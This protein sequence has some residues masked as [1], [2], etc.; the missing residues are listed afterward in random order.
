[1]RDKYFH[2]NIWEV[3]KQHIDYQLQY[4]AYLLGMH[5][6]WSQ[7]NKQNYQDMSHIVGLSHCKL[8]LL[9]SKSRIRCIGLAY[10]LDNIR[11]FY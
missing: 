5:S 4:K 10:Q 6:S 7:L 9:D 2:S 8:S 11:I 1:M 3:S